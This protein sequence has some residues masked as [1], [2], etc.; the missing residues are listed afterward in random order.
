M[1]SARVKWT[2]NRQ[3]I[4]VGEK[5]GHAVV[6]DMAKDKGGEETGLR[7]TELLL[8]STGG[9]TGID[10]VGM[11]EKMR[12]KLTRCEILIKGEQAEDFPKYFHTIKIKY[13]LSGEGLTLK[14]AQKAVALSMG[15]YCSVS[16]TLKGTARVE[17]EIEIV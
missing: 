2:G 5:S 1:I 13:I 12:V 3:F 14:K 8:I 6:M 11:L 7:P 4:G 16:Q 17:T 10:I 9:C 15:T